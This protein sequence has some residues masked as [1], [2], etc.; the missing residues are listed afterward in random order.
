MHHSRARSLLPDVS[1]A[2]GDSNLNPSG[3]RVRY[4]IAERGR[5]KELKSYQASTI[6]KDFKLPLI[7]KH[8]VVDASTTTSSDEPHSRKTTRARLPSIMTGRNRRQLVRDPLTR[9]SN[10][11]TIPSV[12]RLNFGVRG[13]SKCY[14][15]EARGTKTGSLLRYRSTASGMGDTFPDVPPGKH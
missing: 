11:V 5:M 8:P 10:V 14:R 4:D 3:L 7:F 13:C 6:L 2:K 15:L 1:S 12:D 9:S